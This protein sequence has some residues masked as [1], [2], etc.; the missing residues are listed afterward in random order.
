MTPSG[1]H[2]DARNRDAGHDEMQ[3]A[4]F[5][6]L[7]DREVAPLKFK[8]IDEV[9]VRSGVCFELPFM[10]GNQIVAWGDVVEIYDQQTKYSPQRAI[11][12]HEVKPRIYSVGAVVRQCE[13]LTFGVEHA[14]AD[15]HSGSRPVVRVFPAVMVDDPKLAMLRHVYRA[16]A[17]DGERLS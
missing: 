14:L 16:F 5:D 2:D 13:S 10:R 17:W 11:I 1:W 15:R 4:I 9:F 8:D 12:V 3:I 7:K 6:Y